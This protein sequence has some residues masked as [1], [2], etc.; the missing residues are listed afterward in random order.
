MLVGER[1][2]AARNR[3]A[4]LDAADRLF[5]ETPAPDKVSM[6][7]VAHA[8]GLGKGTLFRRF[9]DR[10]SLIR[11]VY[12][13]RIEPLREQIETGPPPLGPAT[14]RHERVPAILA[15]VVQL[16]IDNAHLTLA[17]EGADGVRSEGLY[18]SQSYRDIHLL[19]TS[20]LEPDL[21]QSAGWVAHTLLATVR[22][23]LLRHLV[24]DEGMSRQQ[25]S[26]RIAWLV[27]RVIGSG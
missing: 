17:L 23:D 6:E 19:L 3:R 9:G 13:R 2:D 10:A 27:A 24:E 7:D 21:G 11:A 5:A 25:I 20:L 4:I 14:P 8:A 15:A 16:K 18:A 12:A 1:A 26:E 22:A